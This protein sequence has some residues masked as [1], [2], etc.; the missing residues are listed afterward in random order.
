MKKILLTIVIANSA[1]ASNYV[2]V[3]TS[4]NNS[5]T[6]ALSWGEWLNIEEPYNCIHDITENDVYYGYTANQSSTCDQKQERTR[7]DSDI[8]MTRTVKINKIEEINGTHLENTCV[9]ILEFNSDFLSY[10]GYYYSNLG[11]IYC[12]MTTQG[13]GWTQVANI[14]NA[15]TVLESD[16]YIDN[17]QEKNASFGVKY[18]NAFNPESL[19]F[20]NTS[21]VVDAGSGDL[22]LVT[23]DN[24]TWGWTPYSFSANNTQTALFY[25][26]SANSWTSLGKVTYSAHQNDGNANWQE[27]AFSFAIGLPNPYTGY[28]PQRVILG[29]TFRSNQ[30]KGFAA[31]FYGNKYAIDPVTY[32]VWWGSEAKGSQSIWMR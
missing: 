27:S 30:T 4:D 17:I 28:Y 25:D 8:S 22:V 31:W 14:G 7:L 32:G 9:D 11:E 3:I 6:T 5:Y 21:P 2:S 13:G 20:K 16:S 29:G 1:F 26:N 15:V 10:D 19:L 24:N 23:R 12:D 18:F